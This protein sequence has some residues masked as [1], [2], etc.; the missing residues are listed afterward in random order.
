MEEFE[1]LTG[2]TIYVSATPSDYELEK[3]EGVFVDQ[4]IRPTG[5]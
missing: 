4:V 2:Q 1:A 3:S 5:F